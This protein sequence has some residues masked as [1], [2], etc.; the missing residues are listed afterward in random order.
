MTNAKMKKIIAD[1]QAKFPKVWFNEGSDFGGFGWS[2]EGSDIDGIQAFDYYGWE[3]DPKETIWQMG[4][5]VDLV[6]WADGH[7]LYWECHDPGTY[8]LA[9]K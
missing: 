2:G 4:V 5:H 1:L 3:H 9:E 6:A 7:G 8:C